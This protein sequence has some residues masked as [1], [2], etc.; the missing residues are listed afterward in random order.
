MRLAKVSSAAITF[1][2]SLRGSWYFGGATRNRSPE[3]ALAGYAK[4]LASLDHGRMDFDAP[5]CRSLIPL[6][7]SGYC[8][9][10]EKLGRVEE[11]RRLVAHWRRVYS[12]WLEGPLT[13]PERQCLESLERYSDPT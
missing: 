3:A 1:L 11:A 10:A 4:A 13:A 7:L 2:R 8:A 12:R 9:A 6:A 5:W